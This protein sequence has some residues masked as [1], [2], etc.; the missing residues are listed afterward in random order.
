MS[1]NNRSKNIFITA[2]FVILFVPSLIFSQNI[3]L[4]VGDVSGQ[5]GEKL[6]PLDITISNLVDTLIGF[7][8]WLQLGGFE[9]VKFQEGDVPLK[10][11]YDTSSYIM[12]EWGVHTTSLG[13]N[14]RDILITSVGYTLDYNFLIPPQNDELLIRLYL[15]VVDTFVFPPED[16]LARIDMSTEPSW[17]FS[18]IKPSGESIGLTYNIY[19][20]TTCY[21]C[22]TWVG[23]TCLE[24]QRVPR[25]IGVPID[26][27]LCD[28]MYIVLDTTAILDMNYVQINQGSFTLLPT[29][30]YSLATEDYDI[31]DLVALVDFIFTDGATLT[32]D[33]AD[34]TCDCAVDISDL[35]GFVDF[36]F[37]GGVAPSCSTE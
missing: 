34:F 20:D 30:G 27:S 9:I 35:V 18:L 1:F 22:I 26:P 16:S 31:Y 7:Q 21:E 15:E 23:E 17:H 33:E 5:T 29:C 36:I 19:T 28:S 37:T 24:Y 12:P 32:N 10:Y 8:L 13:G 2:L 3:T 4:T 6:V 14:G 25:V 11:L